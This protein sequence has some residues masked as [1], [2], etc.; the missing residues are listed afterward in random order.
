MSIVFQ[1]T[2]RGENGSAVHFVQ[3]MESTGIAQS[4]RQSSGNISYDYYLSHQDPEVVLL[5]DE[6]ENQAALDAHHQSDNMARIMALREK[7][8]LKMTAKRL[9]SDDQNFSDDDRKFIRE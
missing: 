4:I 8:H 7:Y 5:V 6:W 2:Y 9:I 1:L 3:E